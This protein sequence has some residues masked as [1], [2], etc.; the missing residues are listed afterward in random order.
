M[1]GG[2]VAVIKYVVHHLFSMKTLTLVDPMMTD[3]KDAESVKDTVC[4]YLGYFRNLSACR[5]WISPLTESF[6]DSWSRF[7]YP[8]LC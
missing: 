5:D 6:T 2:A 1:H 7:S 8:R 4:A 3:S